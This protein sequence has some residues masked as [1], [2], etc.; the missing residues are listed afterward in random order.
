M[1]LIPLYWRVLIALGMSQTYHFAQVLPLVWLT[2]LCAVSPTGQL[3]L[4][5]PYQLAPALMT[6]SGWLMV[7]L[8]TRDAWKYA[9]TTNGS[10]YVMM[11]LTQQLPIVC[12]MTG[13]CFLEVSRTLSQNFS[14]AYGYAPY[15]IPHSDGSAVSGSSYG[16][17]TGSVYT[18]CPDISSPSITF[19]PLGNCTTRASDQ[20]CSHE[21]DVGIRCNPGVC[22]LCILSSS[23][24]YTAD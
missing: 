9:E 20:L 21:R 18:V 19:V 15:Y 17:G 24:V 10:Q 5:A 11:A 6:K 7:Q 13:Y 8:I 16:R 2:T 1:E 4:G 23:L 3:V 12:V 14:S 22:K